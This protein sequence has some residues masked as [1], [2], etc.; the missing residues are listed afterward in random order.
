MNGIDVRKEVLSSIVRTDEES[1]VNG[2]ITFVGDVSINNLVSK[3][4]LAKGLCKGWGR[5]TILQ[6]QMQYFLDSIP[7]IGV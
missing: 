1:L 7:R 6:M 2:K 4:E 3:A 5:K